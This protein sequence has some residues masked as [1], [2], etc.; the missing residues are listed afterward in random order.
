MHESFRYAQDIYELLAPE[1]RK[2]AAA[3]DGKAPIAI[4]GPVRATANEKMT[5]WL[6]AVDALEAKGAPGP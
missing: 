5:Q 3:A 6:Q 1:I 4:P 2:A